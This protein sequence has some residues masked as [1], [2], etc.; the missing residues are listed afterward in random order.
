M[1]MLRNL[2]LI[3]FSVWLINKNTNPSQLSFIFLS[4]S[5]SFSPIYPSF[6]LSFSSLHPRAPLPRPQFPPPS[7]SGLA[8]L[9]NN[10]VFLCASLSLSRNSSS[11]SSLVSEIGP[12]HLWKFQSAA[13]GWRPSSMVV[14]GLWGNRIR[15]MV[16]LLG[17][18]NFGG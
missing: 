15:T 17:I 11:F 6:S 3:K 5:L 2:A 18:F 9:T 12:V 8:I 1:Q 4:Y 10:D 7:L 16:F 14:S 13:V